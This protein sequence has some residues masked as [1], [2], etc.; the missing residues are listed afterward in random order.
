MRTKKLRIGELV[1]SLLALLI[2]G[3][4]C[5][6]SDGASEKFDSVGDAIAS[7]DAGA[8]SA[9]DEGAGL[10]TSESATA[11]TGVP[12][13][14]V[15]AAFQEEG[16]AEEDQAPSEPGT[17]PVSEANAVVRTI[18]RRATVHLQVENVLSASNEATI[19]VESYGGIVF[20]QET[21]TRGE[22]RS[23]LTFKVAPEDFQRVI[24]DLAQLGFLRDQTVSA[25]DVTGRVV[26]LQSQITTAETSVERLRAFLAE[27]KDL[28]MITSLEGSLL[29]RESQL[30]L[31]RGQLRTIQ[32]QASLATITVVFT[33]RVPGPVLEVDVTAYPGHDEGGTCPGDDD[34][35]FDEDDLVTLCY[36]LSNTGDTYLSDFTLRDPQMKLDQ[37]DFLEVKDGSLDKPLA[38]GEHLTLYVEIEADPN[39]PAVLGQVGA[40]PTDELGNSLD[41]EGVAGRDNLR[42]D[43]SRD[44]S[45]P[46][47]S[48][49]LAGSW[50]ALKVLITV[51]VLIAGVLLP[52]LWVFPLLYFV[53]RWL[54]NRPRK[55]KIPTYSGTHRSYG[56]AQAQPPAPPPVPAQPVQ[57][58]QPAPAPVSE[59]T[60]GPES[61][62]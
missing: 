5:S 61:G 34:V 10:D 33:E 40:T 13:T 37:E 49:G 19:L 20:G 39:R 14:A 6:S 59:P 23:S 18:I 54:R 42:M 43:I 44:E 24:Q 17:D 3:A 36:R 1:A 28:S 50:E 29:E 32:S 58:D 47:F 52:F 4:G 15:P 31:L 12:A 46:T 62:E 48:D 35:S 9:A 45:L 30:E 7:D 57:T 22:S 38:P 16:E 8:G 56:P 60:T 27:A 2:L 51:L 25:D 53:R 41:I 11:T 26:D 21:S 55:A